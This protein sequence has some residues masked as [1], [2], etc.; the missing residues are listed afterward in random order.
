MR[1]ELV[2]PEGAHS[3][4]PPPKFPTKPRDP[5]SPCRL[6]DQVSPVRRRPCLSWGPRTEV[7]PFRPMARAPAMSPEDRRAQLLEA[8]RT[9]FGRKGYH[10]SG[11]TDI[12]QEAGVARGTFYNHFE[13]KRDAFA[14]VVDRAMNDVVDVV[15]P[16]DVSA[17]IPAQV[18]ANLA[19]LIRAIADAQVVRLLFREA[20]G[21]DSEGDDALKTFYG[22]ALDRIET[23]LRTGQALG[24]VEP[25][26][27]KI[28]ARCLL[29]L[30]KEP[31]VQ[32]TLHG[33]ALDADQ[34][35]RTI[36]GLLQSGL[37]RNSREQM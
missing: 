8:A 30:M 12:V 34:L 7:V 18:T 10:Q 17:P 35:V 15:V 14:A 16:I 9:V 29:G 11:V 31:V 3:P 23:A 22:S 19:R 28:L 4:Q 20:H 21:I 33:E 2:T 36:T 37:L 26:D 1:G 27:V 6:V 24:V 13:S 32:A 25:G 5:P